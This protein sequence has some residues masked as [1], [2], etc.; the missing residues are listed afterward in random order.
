MPANG[1]SRSTSMAAKHSR[2]HR[3]V[4]LIKPDPARR[5]GW[6]GRWTDPDTGRQVK[7]TLPADAARTREGREAWAAGKAD[8]LEARRRELEG[9]APRATGT[10]LADAVAG[11]YRAH[12]RLREKTLAGYRA[13]TG[14]LLAWAAEAGVETTDD[15]TRARLLGLRERL[16]NEGKHGGDAPRSAFSVNRELAALRTVCGYLEER[17]LLTRIRAGDLKRAFR[18]LR[19]PA[20]RVVF[21][22]PVE[23]RAL[24]DAARRHDAATFTATREELAGKRAKGTTPRYEPALPIVRVA[25]LTGMRMGELLRLSWE[26]VDL[27]ARQIHLGAETKTSKARDVDLDVCP[28]VL[29][30]LA[31]TPPEKRSGRVFAAYSQPL[32]TATARRLIA[33]YGAPPRF[34]WQALRRTCGTFLANAGGIWGGAS[35]YRT[36]RQLGH[37]V[38]VSE[39]HYLGVVRVDPAA[40]TLEDAMGLTSP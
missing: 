31:T 14:K 23:C 4:V 7:E 6:R 20:A 18:K 26:Q 28:S 10:P 24:L 27:D 21:L 34:T 32:A 25:L 11:Y 12:P 17:D 16:A 1:T 33:D 36:A 2:R 13:A 9:G 38:Q 39:K 29:E 19:V 5:T 40:K 3:G 22:G 37:S 35:A 30:L 8:A 15:L